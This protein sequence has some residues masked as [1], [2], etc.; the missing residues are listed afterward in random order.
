MPQHDLQSTRE[1]HLE[2]KFMW[3]LSFWWKERKHWWGG[4]T[5][6]LHFPDSA[7]LNTPVSF[8]SPSPFTAF[9]QSVTSFCCLFLWNG[10]CI[11]PLLPHLV[12]PPPWILWPHP[13]SWGSKPRPSLHFTSVLLDGCG[14]WKPTSQWITS[15]LYYQLNGGSLG[16]IRTKLL[17]PP[18]LSG[19]PHI[20]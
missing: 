9:V 7:Q 20:I 8:H 3:S 2:A 10:T 18:L 14:F 11:L 12:L 13:G 5:Y 1:K 4:K 6:L 17:R 19:P 15:P 16:T